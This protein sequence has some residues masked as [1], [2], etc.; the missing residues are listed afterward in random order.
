MNLYVE[1]NI[2]A[3]KTTLTSLL[4]ELVDK[5]SVTLEPVDEWVSYRD[6]DGSSLLDKFYGDI[7]RY[8]YLFQSV[9]FRT[10]IKAFEK[11]IER[12]ESKYN[13]LERSVYADRYCFAQNC[14]ESGNMTQIEWIDYTK[15]FDWLIDMF[16]LDTKIH[17]FIYV[18]TSPEVAHQRLV[19]RQRHGEESI[20]LKYLQ[21]LHEKH[22]SMM[23]LLA[24]KYPV[25][26]I[27]GDQD[28]KNDREIQRKIAEQITQTSWRPLAAKT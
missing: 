16:Q 26:V 22:E 28:F 6:S 11:A 27:D 18:R 17:G 12:S 13:F 5:S 21:L 23:T 3:G 7:K 10:R 8:A 19:K 24:K 9:A 1:G 14:Y 25:L 4:G 20:P 2:G 15:W